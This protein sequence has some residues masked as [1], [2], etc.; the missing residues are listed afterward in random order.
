[1]RNLY[2]Y[3]YEKLSLDNISLDNTFDFPIDG[4]SEEMIDWLENEGFY[5]IYYSGI[6]KKTFDR[7]KGRTVYVSLKKDND[8]NSIYFAD[9]SKNPVSKNNPIFNVNYYYSFDEPS[10]RLYFNDDDNIKLNK[11]EWLK[12]ANKI[13]S[14]K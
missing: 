3:I 11:D 10:F 2:D 13:F 4:T 6:S 9:T 12:A 1:M 8:S 7:R 14:K 5:S